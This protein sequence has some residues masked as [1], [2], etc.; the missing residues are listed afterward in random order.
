MSSQVHVSIM[1][2]IMSKVPFNSLL[3]GFYSYEISWIG[4]GYVF[5]GSHVNYDII[6]SDVL[7]SL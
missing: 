5:T 3:N 7:T 2:S 4:T 6:S 1:T